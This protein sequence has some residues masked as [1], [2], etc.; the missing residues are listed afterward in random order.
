MNILD[1]EEEKPGN[2][3]RTLLPIFL[4]FVGIA[5]GYYL[6]SRQPDIKKKPP[7]KQAVIVE[8][9]SLSPG[10]HQGSIHLMGTVIPDKEV[11]LKSK[12][13]GEVVYLSSGLVVG[14]RVQKGQVLL[15]IDDSD[16]KIEVQKAN[17]ALEKEMSNLAIEQGSQQIAKEELKLINEV[18]SEEMVA[19]DLALRKPQ[20][21]QV[22]AAIRSAKAD[23]EKA[24]LNLSR[25]QVKAPFNAL[26][27]EKNI[28][29]GS[30]VSSQEALCSLVDVDFFQI[31]TQVPP[32]FLAAFVIDETDG[33]KAM[34]HSRYSNQSWQGKVVRTT[35]KM[36]NQSRMAGVIVQVPDPLG[37]LQKK[38]VPPLLL[39]DHVDVQIMG[40]IFKNVYALS[41]NFLKEDQTVWV[42]NEGVLDIRKVKI[43]WKED[44]QVFV[45]SGIRP[46]D[47]LITSDL[48]APVN[49]MA[50]QT[51]ENQKTAEDQK[52]AEQKPSGG[53][54]DSAN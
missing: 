53:D 22:Q 17:S 34:I 46:G 13:S 28:D 39:D 10:D 3:L 43:I 35:G 38:S 24:K 14:G 9:I 4:I 30:L 7:V 23:L 50:L 19:T 36:S 6:F 2:W 18:S 44:G 12:V 8:T 16:Y 51:A 33:S 41:R 27:I 26:V 20:L 48:P 25:T 37:L 11:M 5:G 1:T 29:K 42:Y 15:T 45:S 47:K 32:D 49:G 52:I 40:K 31:E 54:H 21:L